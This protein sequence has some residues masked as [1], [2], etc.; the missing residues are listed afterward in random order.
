MEPESEESESSSSSATAPPSDRGAQFAAVVRQG[1]AAVRRGDSQAAVALYTRAV[2]LG[3][4]SAVL[5]CTRSA[6]LLRVGR[7]HEALQ[8]ARL[9]R[10]L[11]PAYSKVSREPRTR[12]PQGSASRF[13]KGQGVNV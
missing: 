11:E 13:S 9:A 2:A 12:G 10:Q 8:D 3:P 5:H 1:G 6:A 7:H 4:A